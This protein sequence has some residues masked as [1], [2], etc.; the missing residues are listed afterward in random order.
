MTLP[1]L[2]REQLLRYSRHVMLPSFDL[3]GQER[4]LASKVLVI[5]MGGLGCA[6]TPYLVGSGVGKLT[7][8]DDDVVDTHNLPR[9][10]LYQH[11][12]I[13]VAKVVAAQQRL[14]TIN[15]DADINI[16]TQ[17]ADAKLLLSLVQQHDVVVDCCDNLATRNAINAACVAAEKPLV[18]GA[19]IR[20]EGQLS[21]FLNQQHGPCYQCFSLLFGEQQLSCMES[22]I[23]APVVGVIGSMQAVETLKL[24]AQ[25]GEPIA[26]HV[27]LYDGLHGDWQKFQLSRH[28][29]CPLCNS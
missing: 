15:A 25:I 29:Q 11:D 2:T 27:L 1:E 10:T 16:L 9:Q 20:Y 4:I 14:R 24:L 8:V 26:G 12:D 28:P 19:A 3:N 7:L 6:V 17:R 22:G 5:G 23:L 21:V 18:S 13:G